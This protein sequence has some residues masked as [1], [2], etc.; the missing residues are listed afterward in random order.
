MLCFSLCI[1]RNDFSTRLP[2][3]KESSFL[4]NLL[5]LQFRSLGLSLQLPSLSIWL[6]PSFLG[7]GEKPFPIVACQLRLRDRKR[8]VARWAFK[9][10]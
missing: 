6:A 8:K 10:K 2:A 5:A 9:S 7:L 3:P 1:R 4:F